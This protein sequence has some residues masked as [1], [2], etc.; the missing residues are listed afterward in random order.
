LDQSAVRRFRGWNDVQL[1]N[2]IS[3]NKL[4]VP[5]GAAALLILVLVLIGLP[6]G[7]VSG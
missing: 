6:M 1:T 7:A 4:T 5:F 2:A 3:L